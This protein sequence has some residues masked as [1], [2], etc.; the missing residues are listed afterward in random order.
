MAATWRS[1][2]E[3]AR[4]NRSSFPFPGIASGSSE[5][6]G[7][8]GQASSKQRRTRPPSREV[9]V[10]SDESTSESSSTSSEESQD[11]LSEDSLS[12]PG[13]AR[14]PKASHSAPTSSHKH[15]SDVR[16]PV[17]PDKEVMSDPP[18]LS[19]GQD[20]DWTGD[21][22]SAG[23]DAVAGKS[24]GASPSRASQPASGS[25]PSQ[26]AAVSGPC[27]ARRG[28]KRRLEP[29]FAVAEDSFASAAASAS[30]GSPET[31]TRGLWACVPRELAA[32]VLSAAL[33]LAYM[34]V[35]HPDIV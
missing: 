29:E 18:S 25:A 20:F 11:P 28:I 33:V 22:S 21:G 35:V 6:S 34:Y 23:E 2:G 7:S 27:T 3:P 10:S 30:L 13:S 14:T 8:Q 26:E 31:P 12:Q 16:Q 17:G 32:Q 5:S 15:P 9:V 19:L 1:L 24:S 4:H